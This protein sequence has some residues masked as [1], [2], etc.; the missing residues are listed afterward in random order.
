MRQH[1]L[2]RGTHAT[3]HVELLRWLLVLVGAVCCLLAGGVQTISVSELATALHALGLPAG[4]GVES[5][6]K[7]MDFDEDGTLNL[8]EFLVATSEV[9]CPSQCSFLACVVAHC[10]LVWLAGFVA[11]FVYRCK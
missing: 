2:G 10:V 3:S 6:M 7:Q 8:E 1:A 11:R 9:R 4:T 5:L